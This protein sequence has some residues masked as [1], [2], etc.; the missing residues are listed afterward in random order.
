MRSIA[1]ASIGSILALMY[2][3]A[4]AQGNGG[5]ETQCELQYRTCRETANADYQFCK[6]ASGQDCQEKLDAALRNCSAASNRCQ[7]Q[8]WRQSPR[9][10]S[11]VPKNSQA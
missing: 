2:G 3:L 11:V 5:S 7:S 6:T 4:P 10:R 9:I 8:S 1:F